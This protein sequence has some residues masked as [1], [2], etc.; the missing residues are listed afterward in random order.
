MTPTV[1]AAPTI[2]AVFEVFVLGFVV[3]LALFV[4]LL[5]AVAAAVDD[6]AAP[7]VDAA[8]PG[9]AAFFALVVFL[10]AAGLAGDF[11]AAVRL[12]LADAE[13]AA[14]DRTSTR[15]NSSH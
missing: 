11:W 9:V 13:D 6:L 14:G 7:V 15:L 12:G 4:L 3:R 8:R 5:P 10:A 2:F 1:A